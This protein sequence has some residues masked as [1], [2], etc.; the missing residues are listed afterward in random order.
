MEG[1]GFRL[2]LLEELNDRQSLEDW[3]RLASAPP[4]AVHEIRDIILGATP[5]VREALGVQVEEGRLSLTRRRVVL[6]GRKAS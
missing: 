6:V 3:F 1:A 5:G 4:E 2:L